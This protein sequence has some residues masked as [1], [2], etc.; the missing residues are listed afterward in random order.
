MNGKLLSCDFFLSPI[1]IGDE[2]KC[3]VPYTMLRIN[4]FISFSS[5]CKRYC[6]GVCMLIIQ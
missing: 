1:N 2:I 6:K 4:L 5:Q 3:N